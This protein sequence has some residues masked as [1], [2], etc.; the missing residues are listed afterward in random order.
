MHMPERW[1]YVQFSTAKLGTTVFRPDP[2]DPARHVLHQVYYAQRDFHK[3]HRRWAATLEEL[4]LARLS[5]A[6]LTKPLSMA[7]LPGGFQATAAIQRPDGTP[8][9]WHIRQDAKVWSE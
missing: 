8:Q 6:S 2:A 9:Q 7:V 5:H 3:Q 4:N 1:G